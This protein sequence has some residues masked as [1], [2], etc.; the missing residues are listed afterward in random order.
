MRNSRKPEEV[1]VSNYWAK[2]RLSRRSILR[3]AALGGAGLT[4]AALIGCS[5]DD[6]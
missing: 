1:H 3:G 2:K 5:S 6:E 4:G